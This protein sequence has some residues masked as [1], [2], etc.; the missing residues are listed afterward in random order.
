MAE[1]S[2]L[3]QHINEF[4]LVLANLQHFDVKYQEDDN[5]LMLLNSLLVPCENLAITLTWENDHQKL[6]VMGALLAYNSR[7]KANGESS[8]GK[9]L[10]V[11][12]SQ[13]RG[14]GKLKNGSGDKSRSKSSKKKDIQ[15]YKYRKK[16][17]IKCECPQ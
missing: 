17:H 9:G 1:S 10:V 16:R 5:L 3:M 13:D 2:D 15:C 14:R 7:K 6:E 12:S 8:Q 4:N 11:K